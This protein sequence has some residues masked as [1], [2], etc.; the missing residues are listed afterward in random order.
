MSLPDLSVRRPVAMSCLII[1]LAILGVNAYR[2]MGLELM[3]SVDIPYITVITVYPGATPEEIE[4]DIAKR[5]ED[6]MVTIAGLKHVGSTCIEN[7]CQ[8][9]LEFRLGID[10]D[11]AATDVREKLDL[12]RN[13]FP[14]DVEDPIVM[15]FDVNATPIITLALTGDATV[16]E[17]FDYGDNT[18]RD[19][20]TVIPGVADVTLVGGSKREVHVQLDRDKVAARGL[21]SLHVVEAIKSGVR[22]IPA[23]RIRSDG[24]E[25]VVKFDGDMKTVDA[26]NDLEITGDDG[27]RCYVRDVGHAFMTTKELREAAFFDGAPAISI[28]VVK[29]SEANAVAVVDEVKKA[30]AQI[31]EE[32]P[33][34]MVLEWVTDDGTFTRAVIDSAWSDVIQGVILTAIILFLFLYNIRSTFIVA[35]TMPLTLVIGLFF[36]QMLGYTLNTM[37]L[38]SMGLSVGIL[39]TNSIVV[40]ESIVSGLNAGLPPKEAARVGSKEVFV[41]VLASASTN[42]VVLFPLAVM[43]TMVGLFI[44]PFVWTMLIVTVVSL[45][46]SFTLTPL[47]ASL[48]LRPVRKDSKHPLVYM[49]RAWDWMF[50]LV[51]KV[52][53]GVLILTERYRPLAL[54]VVLGIGFLFVFTLGQAKNL[55]MSLGESPDRGEL[56]IKAEFPTYYSME[57][58]LGRLKEM[59]ALVETL[60]HLRHC[61]SRVG[62]VEAGF[63]RSSDGVYLAQILLRFNERTERKETIEDLMEEVRRRMAN[64]PDCIQS[65]AQPSFVGGQEAPIQ[66]EV[67]GADLTVLDSLA[68]KIAQKTAEAPGFVD[69]DTSVRSGKPELRVRPD[70]TVLSD[71][72]IPP[73]Q[74]G[75]MLRGNLE[76]IT[77][78]TYKQDARN[79]DIVVKFSDEE[80]KNQIRDFLL[81]AAP[82]RPIPLNTVGSVQE[83]TTPVQIPRKDKKRVAKVFADLSHDLSLGDGVEEIE[84]IIQTNDLLPPGYSHNFAGEYEIM[85]EG[86]TEM[87]EAGLIA[88]I[89]VILTLAALLESFKQPFLILVTLPIGLIG[90]IWALLLTGHAMSIF[91][92]MSV[93]MLI[94][95]VV[96]NAI[97]IV[98]QFNQMVAKGAS[99]HAAMIDAACDQFRPI[100]MITLAGILG[101][102]P[103]ALGKGIGAEM[104][105]G[106]GIASV[107]GMFASGILSLVLVPVLYDLF[108]RKA[109][110]GKKPQD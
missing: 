33:G 97:L 4:T 75:M 18:L 80:G 56:F 34:G 66:L 10:V 96:N 3:P 59:E 60:P 11:I 35:V 1:A 36:I 25:Y 108:T 100:I 57:T 62:K 54:L 90:V 105:N 46:I 9:L 5:I 64:F 44:G 19:R 20:L 101:M 84:R 81:P 77:A 86:Q 17:L 76:G 24:S 73:L 43:K 31:N 28:Q 78:G 95:I 16:E 65:V 61:V 40:I 88:I 69:L 87:A 13:D 109:K 47:L 32:L 49:Q 67:S 12:V 55:G 107:G 22:T 37:T 91:V 82:G 98:D 27:S 104:R 79:Y 38:L 83:S 92:L 2:K 29:R 21:T 72:G 70:R 63:G 53:R 39:V 102:M 110:N 30:I 26:I 7:A 85:K 106:V 99:R 50:G 51:V 48:I 23:G 6:K 52:Y 8:T 74:L 45:F 41:A 68:L 42:M 89:L 14:E 103:L 94:G 71:M 15:K 93:V 58:T